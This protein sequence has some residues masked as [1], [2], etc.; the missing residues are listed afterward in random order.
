MMWSL[1]TLPSALR[2]LF[3]V[4]LGVWLAL[5]KVIPADEVLFDGS[6]P[7]PE[8]PPN[9]EW[10]NTQ[11]PIAMA[12]L[13][14]KL[15]LIDFWTYCCINCMHV[16][17]DLKKLEAKY[18]RELVVLGVHSAKFTNEKQTDNIRQAIKRYEIEHPVVNDR[19]FA[20]WRLYGARAWPSLVLINPQ[21]RIIGA[22]SGEG[23]FDLFDSILAQAI[24]H[25]D[26][27]KALDRRPLEFALE[28]LRGPRS[29]LAYP[30]KIV[31]DE[32]TGR[33][34]FSDSNNNRI[35]VATPD[36]HILEAIGGPDAGLHDGDYATARFFRPQGLCHDAI[37]ELLYVADTENHVLRQ[38]DL[39]RK[40]VSLIAGVGRQARKHNAEGDAR[41][42]ALN[43]PWDVLQRG[44]DLF[45]AMAG[46]HQIWRLDLRSGDVSV[47]AGTSREYLTDG[48]LKEAAL[49]Q[50]SGL[51]TDGNKLYFAD[52]EVSAVRMAD[53]SPTGRVDTL[54]GTGLFDF[55]D[56]DGK[57]PSA[58]LQHCLGV[59][60][61][62]GLVYVADTYNHKIKRVDA[63]TREVSTFVGTGQPGF[64]DG[65]RLAAQLNE[66]GGL[67]FVK[68]KLL[69]AD[70]NNHLIRSCDLKNGRVSTVVF[71]EFDR[72]ER[73]NTNL[74]AGEKILLRALRVSPK[75]ARL[76][77]NLVLPEGTHLNPL[78]ASRVQ[79]T[80]V[81]G[82]AIKLKSPPRE[83]TEP[84]VTIPWEVLEGPSAVHLDLDVYYCAQKNAGLCYFKSVRLVLP[85]EVT[86][87]GTSE[88]SVDFRLEN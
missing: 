41:F 8:F 69:I 22:H 25:F 20:I 27:T 38:I 48:P 13:R 19:D 46:A 63:R 83:L 78:A 36:G 85:V 1:R 21:G 11:K 35:I 15:V 70:S 24:S 39:K 10:L 32:K 43:S 31:A 75:T 9:L 59:A 67:C 14:G 82:R 30:G 74:L 87:S 7:A 4:C 52:S 57:Y 17:P 61:R 88:P 84:K 16:I 23:A 42:T 6:R 37:N 45:V 33:I 53:L 44:D 81:D 65:D 56:V 2:G 66:P 60:C 72:L 73:G 18:P 40:T 77:L 26:T 5:I 76:Q 34:F 47:Y 50:P 68:D 64:L 54:I 58:R 79:A 86:A 71:K 62:E 12:D 55:G 28:R 49:A 3:L 51:A 29:L 80:A